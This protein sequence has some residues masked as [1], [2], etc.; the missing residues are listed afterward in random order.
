MAWL[1]RRLVRASGPAPGTPAYRVQEAY[2]AMSDASRNG[3]LTE[4]NRAYQEL[5][6]AAQE[7]GLAQVI[8][9]VSDINESLGIEGT[10]GDEAFRVAAHHL[11]I[12]VYN[13]KHR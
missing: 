1:A 7:G 4:R 11:T 5:A 2:L 6:V 12:A 13:L 3:D 9:A 10:A 8:A